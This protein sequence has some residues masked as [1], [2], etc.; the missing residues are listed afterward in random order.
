M[1]PRKR[2]SSLFRWQVQ[3]AYLIKWSRGNAETVNLN[4]K[5]KYNRRN[6]PDLGN[7][8][9]ATPKEIEENYNVIKEILKWNETERKRKPRIK[10]EIRRRQRK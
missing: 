2:F 7:N 6:I 9:A 3:E 10:E 8:D 5:P 4:S 1:F